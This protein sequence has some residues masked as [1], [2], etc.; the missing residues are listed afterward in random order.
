MNTFFG[1]QS[2]FIVLYNGKEDMPEEKE[3]RLSD[4]FKELAE[5]ETPKLELVV[6]V[7]NIN[8]G[9]NE[10]FANRSIV[11][12]DYSIFIYLVREY[13][14]TMSRDKAIFKAIEDCIRQNVLKDF[15]EE[16]SSEVYNMLFGKW[17]FEEELE[18]R[19]DEATRIGEAKGLSQGLIQAAKAMKA[20]GEA[21]SK[22]IRYTGLSRSEI[23][24]L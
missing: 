15:L 9:H 18:V 22:I 24:S 6:K 10:D 5:G 20:S 3:L 21:M 2:K 8:K 4:M 14:K 13:A 1:G 23:A 12:K 16:H 7:Y 17:D 11:L 19:V